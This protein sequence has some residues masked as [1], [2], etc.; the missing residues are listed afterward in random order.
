MT[1]PESSITEAFEMAKQMMQSYQ[2]VVQLHADIRRSLERFELELGFRNPQHLSGSFTLLAQLASPKG[3]R[4]LVVIL[5]VYQHKENY[6]DPDVPVELVPEPNNE[7]L[8]SEKCRNAL[9]YFNDALK[10][11]SE[12]YRKLCML[13]PSLQDQEDNLTRSFYQHSSDGERVV[14]AIQPIPKNVIIMKDQ[15]EL[16]W[17]AT[18]NAQLSLEGAKITNLYKRI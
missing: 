17:K 7:S 8:L 2:D 15:V 11:C 13:L 12:L 18:C 14:K 10:Q 16:F 3:R 5:I 1:L 6:T 9:I 4:S